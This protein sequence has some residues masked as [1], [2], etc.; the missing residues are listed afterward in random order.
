MEERVKDLT[1][2]VFGRLT[3][4]G[5]VGRS[6]DKKILWACRCSCGKVKDA[7]VASTTLKS[8]NTSSCGCLWAESQRT[9]AVTHGGSKTLEYRAWKLMRQR[10]K[11]PNN[12]NYEAYKERLPDNYFDDFA[13]F[14]AEVGPRPG[15]GYSLDRVNNDLGYIKGNIRWAT[16]LEQSSNRKSN[17]IVRNTQTGERM[18]LAEACRRA[19]LNYSTVRYRLKYLGWT[20]TEATKGRYT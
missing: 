3:V 15:P 17:K 7:P 13:T 8:G 14:L 1:G 11:N 10:T 18:T 19:E 20:T 16:K 5:P 2:Q 12:P 6:K 4:L 9:R